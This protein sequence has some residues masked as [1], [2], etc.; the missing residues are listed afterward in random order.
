[1]IEKNGIILKIE[2]LKTGK[3]VPSRKITV[4]C[5]DGT[6]PSAYIMQTADSQ[7][8]L[9]WWNLIGENYGW[10]YF[11]SSHA[12]TLI[13]MRV[14]ITAENGDFGWQIKRVNGL[15]PIDSK[16][17]SPTPPPTPPP[18]PIAVASHVPPADDI[19]F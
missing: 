12:D 16:P 7:Y 14:S 6:Y 8:S 4:K 11:A 5:D 19:P 3:G 18:P 9:C 2:I 1:M 17:E 13:G 10:E 15:A